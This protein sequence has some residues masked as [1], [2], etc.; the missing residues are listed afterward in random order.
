MTDAPI[1]QTKTVTHALYFEL[2]L[3]T[4]NTRDVMFVGPTPTVPN[5]HGAIVSRLCTPESNG[6]WEVV[7]VPS[8]AGLTSD[9]ARGG[10]INTSTEPRREDHFVNYLTVIG[11]VFSDFGGTVKTVPWTAD[12]PAMGFIQVTATEFLEMNWGSHT[13]YG[14]KTPYKMLSRAKK[15]YQAVM[16]SD[17]GALTEYSYKGAEEN[18]LNGWL[19]RAVTFLPNSNQRP[20]IMSQASKMVAASYVSL[21]FDMLERAVPP[22]GRIQTPA[23]EDRPP[24]RTESLLPTVNEYTRPN[25]EMYYSR[26]WTGIEDVEVLKTAREHSQFPLLYGPPGTG[27]TALAEATY[28][29]DLITVMITGDTEVSDLVGQFIPNPKHGEKGEGEYIW[30]DGPL[31]RA[32]LEGRPILL[33]EIGLGDPKMLSVVYPLMDGRRE[34]QVTSNPDR[35]VISVTDGFF[36]L[37]ATNPDAPGVQMS[38]A[39]MSRFNLH[40]EVHTDWELA[41]TRLGVPEKI[42][43]IAQG[44]SKMMFNGKISWAPQLR[45]LLTYKNLAAIYGEKFALANLLA[46][47]PPEDRTVV[48]ERVGRVYTGDHLPARIGKNAEDPPTL[49]L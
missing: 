29:T 8:F 32:A 2:L 6:H 40:V 36:L 46:S 43:G 21:A 27:K 48:L 14:A 10:R 34:L 4:G 22:M 30:V 44:L 23:L 13:D 11:E 26:N 33:D 17:P 7:G 47:C 5:G 12:K 20:I 41:V 42:A 15:H 35:G 25:G 37:G 9:P 28:G 16:W 3:E 39:L 49:A 45:E 31:V 24:S 38:E 18:T 1:S 19:A